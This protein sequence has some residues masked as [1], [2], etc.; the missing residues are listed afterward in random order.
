MSD[1][2]TVRKRVDTRMVVLETTQS[3][4]AKEMGISVQALG[5]MLAAD[6]RLSSLVR[7]AK[8]LK[9][10]DPSALVK[11]GSDV[12]PELLV[13]RKGRSERAS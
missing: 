8:A 9:L 1:V 10:P 4:V 12:P 13:V 6:M 7:L 5:Q 2:A 11:A 3:D